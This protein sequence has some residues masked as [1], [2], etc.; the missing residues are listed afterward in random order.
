MTT[1]VQ[2]NTVAPASE[3]R[4]FTV[5]VVAAIHV[6]VIYAIMVGLD[7]VPS[8]VPIPDFDGRFIPVKTIVDYPPPP[9]VNKSTFV[10]PDNPTAVP[11]QIDVDHGGNGGG[12]PYDPGRT[13]TDTVTQV[14]AVAGTHTIPGYPSLD[15]RL[16]HE[17]TVLLAIWIDAGGN[18]SQA[19]VT[20]SSG[21]DGL[22]RAAI[23]WV[24]AHW[25]YKP[26]T[27][28]GRPVP[29]SAQASV[30]F[31]LTQG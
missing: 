24:K 31:R 4:T 5:A 26:A 16:G 23:D 7:I 11:P 13:Q 17:G 21:Y 12:I 20:R 14:S 6:A 29:S 18:V 9:P 15:R 25:R 8:P 2:A 30:T 19:T 1:L 3:R 10:K 27:K 28:N 22:D